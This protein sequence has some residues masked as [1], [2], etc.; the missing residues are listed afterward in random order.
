MYCTRRTHAQ[1][2]RFPADKHFPLIKRI[3]PRPRVRVRA[4]ESGRR[5]FVRPYCQIARTAQSKC[6]HNM[7][8]SNERHHI[9]THIDTSLARLPRLG[10]IGPGAPG[11]DG[12]PDAGVI[13]SARA[14]APVVSGPRSPL[15]SRCV[16]VSLSV[17]AGHC[18]DNMLFIQLVS[19]KVTHSRTC[20]N[21]TV[22]RCTYNGMRMCTSTCQARARTHT[23]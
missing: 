11:P 6:T 5:V 9:A 7:Q 19:A 10:E 20:A 13:A 15:R 3:A 8:Y 12:R 4:R 14:V 16:C 23:R 1:S 21:T 2:I 18:H 17:L 22:N